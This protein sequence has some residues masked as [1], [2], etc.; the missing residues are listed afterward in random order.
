[1]SYDNREDYAKKHVECRRSETC[2][3]IRGH[4]GSCD[5]R[6]EEQRWADLLADLDAEA[7][8]REEEATI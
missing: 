7:K 2:Q 6:R 4:G 8:E 5:A 1:M 3:L